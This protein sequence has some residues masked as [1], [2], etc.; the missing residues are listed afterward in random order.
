[1]S[2]RRRLEDA[3][4]LLADGRVEGALLSICAAISATSRK[5]Y[6]DREMINDRQAFTMFLGEEIRVASAGAFVN[7]SVG[8]PRNSGDQSGK[9]TMPLQDVLYKFVRCML[10]HEGRVGANVEFASTDQLSFEMRSDRMI[11]GGQL[12]RGLLRVVEYAPENASEFPEVAEIP[13]DVI[14][15]LLFGKRRQSQE[16]Y[17]KRRQ[18]RLE[19][20]R[21]REVEP[22]DQ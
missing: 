19:V 12:L 14:G 1:M 13:Q 10:A 21:Q 9:E 3:E 22:P 20:V 5:R 6:P 7:L 17:L 15:W 18:L 2:I 16:E 4:F 8:C 11:L